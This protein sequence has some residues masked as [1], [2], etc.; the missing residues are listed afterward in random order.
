MCWIFNVPLSILSCWKILRIVIVLFLATT[1][2]FFL[3]LIIQGCNWQPRK[4]KI[5]VVFIWKYLEEKVIAEF[6]WAQSIIPLWRC[7]SITHFCQKCA[8]SRKKIPPSIWHALWLDYWMK[9][10]QY[11][12]KNESLLPLGMRIKN[13]TF[14]A[15]LDTRNRA[16]FIWIFGNNA[17]FSKGRHSFLRGV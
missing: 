12:I 2:T 10:K 17:I 8:D 1:Q 3:A 6:N 4:C 11:P 9:F 15:Q 16:G 5:N 13:L 7:H 14:F